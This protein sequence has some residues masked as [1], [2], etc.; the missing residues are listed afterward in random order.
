MQVRTLSCRTCGTELRGDFTPDPL[1]RLNEAQRQF[2]ITFLQVGG[3]LKEMERIMGISYPTVRARL[4]EILAGLGVQP[5]GKSVPTRHEIL[6]LLAQ[7]K[8]DSE[9]AARQLSELG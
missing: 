6:E 4:S 2:V 3:N 5:S 1:T 8:L 7:G 9:E